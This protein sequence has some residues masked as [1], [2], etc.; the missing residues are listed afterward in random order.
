MAGG[1]EL[2]VGVDGC[3]GDF[4]VEVAA[5]LLGGFGGVVGG[6]GVVGF[7]GTGEEV[8]GVR[9][10]DIDW[11]L[12][13]SGEGGLEGNGENDGALMVALAEEFDTVA[14][15][16]ADVVG[17]IA[18]EA[19]EFVAVEAADFEVGFGG[20]IG[21]DCGGVCDGGVGGAAAGGEDGGEVDRA[22]VEN[23]LI[24]R[25]KSGVQEGARRQ[26]VI[27]AVLAPGVAVNDGESEDLFAAVRREEG[28]KGLRGLNF[29]MFFGSGL[30]LGGLF[31]G[32]FG[33]NFGSG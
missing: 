15:E 1:D 2:C 7:G 29:A 20:N 12:F 18:P 31:S 9:H 8:V 23:D 11:G 32:L 25:I 14:V 13:E 26:G 4:M 22:A 19:G 6:L 30:L 16:S 5:E 24:L 17:E 3:A 33:G 27:L 21:D 10:G 28:I